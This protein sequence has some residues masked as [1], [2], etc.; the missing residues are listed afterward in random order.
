[1]V[2]IYCYAHSVVK[3][4]T[5]KRILTLRSFDNTID[6]GSRFKYMVPEVDF[7][8]NALV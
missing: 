4:G 3:E 6:C 1:M 2:D 7:S 5:S 8:Y